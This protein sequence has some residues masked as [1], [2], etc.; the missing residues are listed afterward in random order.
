MPFDGTGRGVRGKE[1]FDGSAFDQKHQDRSTEQHD[2]ERGH[3]GDER[4]WL[5]QE[6]ARD[7]RKDLA[8][9]SLHEIGDVGAQQDRHQ[10]RGADERDGQQH[11]KRRGGDEL[12]GNGRPVRGGQQR[13]ALEQ[14]LE[15][16]NRCS[17]CILS[18]P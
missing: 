11:L 12:N 2:A 4:D 16:Q 3:E 13:A 17:N 8:H 18:S 1:H 6:R 9:V 15:V 5:G 10:N 14:Q 7:G